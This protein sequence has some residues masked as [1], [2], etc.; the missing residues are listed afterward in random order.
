MSDMNEHAYRNRRDQSNEYAHGYASDFTLKLHA[1]RTAKQQASWFLPYLQPGM[2]LLDCGCGAGSITV[3]LAAT[4]TPGYVTGI[5][6]AA[7]EIERARARAIEAGLANVHFE[8]GNVCQLAYPDSVFDTVFAHNVLEH[9]A[10][11][12]QALSEMKRVL[13]SGGMIGVRDIDF[14]GH[15]LATEDPLVEQ[16]HKVFEADWQGAGGHPRLGRQL[17]KLLH[18]AGFVDI[19][20]SASYEVYSSQAATKWW[21]QIAAGRTSDPDF[22]HRAINTNLATTSELEQMKQAYLA[23]GTEPGAFFGMAHGEA[24]AWKL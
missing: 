24:I 5:D 12:A 14:G 6:I 7:T 11:P 21:S 1:S 18:Q 2:A 8:I 9:L 19:A 20:A 13:K 22:M 3:G 15:I 16:Y 17:H 4:V 23:W 10:D